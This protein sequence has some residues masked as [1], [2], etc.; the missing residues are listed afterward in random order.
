MAGRH[1][2]QGPPH[3]DGE[4]APSNEFGD[5]R[6]QAMPQSDGGTPFD[7]D[8][9][10]AMPQPDANALFDDDRTQAMPASAAGPQEPTAAY[11]NRETRRWPADDDFTDDRTRVFA[12]QP[13]AHD[14]R[15]D[16]NDAPTTV[17]ETPVVPVGAPAADGPG[18][19]HGPGAPSGPPGDTPSD[20]GGT[21][22]RRWLMWGAIIVILVLVVGLVIALFAL[23]GSDSNPEPTT[24]AT[25]STAPTQEPAPPAPPAPDPTQPVEEQ[26]AP[27]ITAFDVTPTSVVCTGG[28]SIPLTFTW[29]STDAT[30]GWI[31]VGTNDAQAAPYD[32]VSP[33]GGSYSD[34]AFQCG[35]DSQTYALTVSGPG[36][37][38]SQ[39]ITV[40]ATNEP[41][42]GQDTD[43]DSG[44]ETSGNAD[45]SGS[46]SVDP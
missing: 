8:R 32:S 38:V 31:G 23:N 22:K 16:A 37:T 25:Q 41:S 3:E 11:G 27:V 6:T 20:T 43:A 26:E 5:D 19:A 24:T 44:D 29:S 4:A 7:D 18:G 30:E 36:G 28:E 1:A 14:A 35:Q 13:G 9:T 42:T 46:D 39:S 40:T 2:Q 33:G 17:F 12:T 21:R 34:I 45:D 10:Q 15:Y